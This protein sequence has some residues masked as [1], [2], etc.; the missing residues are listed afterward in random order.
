MINYFAPD[1]LSTI[2][3]SL[4]HIYN[5]TEINIDSFDAKFFVSVLIL[6]VY[7]ISWPK[8]QMANHHNHKA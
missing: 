2:G 3:G 8:R 6:A 7:G 5:M 4:A 1:L